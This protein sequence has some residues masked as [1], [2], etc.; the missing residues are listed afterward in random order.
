MD[1]E[2]A[3]L[4]SVLTTAP[5]IANLVGAN[6]SLVIDFSKPLN[7]GTA[8]GGTV[9]ARRGATVLNVSLGTSGSQLT[10][11]APG[12]GWGAGDFRVELD[13]IRATD[14]TELSGAV[15]LPFQR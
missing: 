1:E 12:G 3:P 2:P 6:E 15:V 8:N 7:G 9:R 10:I 5:A 14:G 13:G 11:N 4:L